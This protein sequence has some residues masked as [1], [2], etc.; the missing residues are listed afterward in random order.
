ML[1]LL[2]SL[3]QPSPFHPDC[4]TDFVAINQLSSFF[5]GRGTVQGHKKT[6]KAHLD[7]MTME[8]VIFLNFPSSVSENI[9][10]RS[11]NM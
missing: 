8:S 10:Q 1:T 5:Y 6:L 3:L 7:F 2:S 11:V 4:I 9:S